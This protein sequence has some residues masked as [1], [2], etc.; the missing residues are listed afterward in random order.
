MLIKKV[1]GKRDGKHYLCKCDT[2]GK[3]FKR[4]AHWVERT[5]HQF[6]NQDCASIHKSKEISGK[7]N[8]RWNGGVCFRKCDGYIAIYDPNKNAV[9]PYTMQHR[10]IMEEFLGRRLKD[11]EV[12]H[13]INGDRTDNRLENLMLFKNAGEHQKY[14]NGLKKAGV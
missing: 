5:E 7:G 14:H 10:K 12:V 6:C 2:C 1:V 3:E 9:R 4:K 13:H 8:G 11:E